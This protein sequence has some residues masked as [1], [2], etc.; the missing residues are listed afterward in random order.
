MRQRIAAAIGSLIALLC[1]MLCLAVLFAP[2]P[3]RAALQTDK[4]VHATVSASLGSM[5]RL[6]EPD[7]VKAWG[8]AMA[9]GLAKELYDARRGG[10]GFSV[11]DL[12]A[13]A[14]GAYVGVRV[15]GLA[16]S[17]NRITYQRRF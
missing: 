3:S 11:P 1:A 5:A 4:V 12:I 7:P 9:P 6:V 2:D 16:I 10:T 17:R 8:L 15:A 14:I 13:D